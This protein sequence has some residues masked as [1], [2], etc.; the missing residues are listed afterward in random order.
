MM[1]IH[2]KVTSVDL[3]NIIITIIIIMTIK[4]IRIII[5]TIKIITNDYILRTTR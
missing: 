4:I 2:G 3:S 1:S 5:I